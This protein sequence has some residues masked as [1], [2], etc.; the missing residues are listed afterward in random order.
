[1]GV[2]VKKIWVHTDSAPY[3]HKQSSTK[4][5]SATDVSSV[6]FAGDD[7]FTGS[8][9]DDVIRSCHSGNDAAW[10]RGGSDMVSGGAGDDTLFGGSSSDQLCGDDDDDRLY[11]G[12]GEGD[13]LF[14][15]EG[16]DLLVLGGNGGDA[17]GDGGRDTLRGGAGNDELIGAADPDRLDG[18]GGNDFLTGG[19]ASDTMFGGAGSD[20][21]DGAGADATPDG[22]PDRGD[23]L[24]GK[25]GDDQIL[26]YA[27][28]DM[29]DGGTGN[30]SMDGGFGNDTFH[31]DSEHDVIGEELGQGI[32]TVFTTSDFS[33]LAMDHWSYGDGAPR[34]HVVEV[35]IA[36]SDAGLHLTGDEIDQ[37][38]RGAGGNDTLDGGGGVDTLPGGGGADTFALSNPTNP[39]DGRYAITDLN[40]LEGDVFDVGEYFR[41]A[42]GTTDSFDLVASGFTGEAGQV[43]SI[44][45]AQNTRILFDMTGDRIADFVIRL[46]GQH[47]VLESDFILA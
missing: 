37:T 29:I 11:G 4:I 15:G 24:F 10:G 25:A 43:R 34:G 44:I 30:D 20:T 13:R 28:T 2:C 16:R 12:S 14:G 39:L 35:I 1:M 36:S 45:G 31:V 23:S 17:N 42:L 7:S 19:S 3:F 32:D 9:S 26:G 46:S 41:V 47:T 27:Q 40:P 21:L 33:L 5:R 22:A 18:L 6:I 38:D 8:N